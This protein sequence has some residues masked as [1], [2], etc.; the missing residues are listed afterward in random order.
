MSSGLPIK[1]CCQSDIPLSLFKQHLILFT[2]MT[3]KDTI[4]LFQRFT[5]SFCTLVSDVIHLERALH[6]PGMYIQ[7]Q[8]RPVSKKPEKK[9]YGSQMTALNI[10]GTKKAMAKLLI[11]LE[12]APTEAPFARMESGKISEISV[13]ETGPQVAPKP[14]T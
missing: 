13:Q 6:I 12:N 2:G 8:N 11:Q 14:P 9:I 5:F 4:H 3:A 1:V 10:V 7:T